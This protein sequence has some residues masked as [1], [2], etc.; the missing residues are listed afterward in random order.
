MHCSRATEEIAQAGRQKALVLDV[1]RLIL[2]TL[3]LGFVLE[4]DH[5][6]GAYLGLHSV[7]MPSEPSPA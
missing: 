1:P 5:G 4:G 6:C 3:L 7:W 2:Q